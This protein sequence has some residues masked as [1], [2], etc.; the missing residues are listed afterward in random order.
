MANLY[1][2]YNPK[3]IERYERQ[4][5]QDCQQN[6]SQLQF[7][8]ISDEWNKLHDLA[9]KGFQEANKR[10][11]GKRWPIIGDSQK[12]DIS[13]DLPQ[14][15]CI[16][17]AFAD[18]Y[19]LLQDLGE[20][21]EPLIS[22]ETRVEFKDVISELRDYV[23]F[24]FEPGDEVDTFTMCMVEVKKYIG[25]DIKRAKKRAK[26]KHVRKKMSKRKIRVAFGDDIK[27][28]FTFNE[29][30]AFFDLKDLDLPSGEAVSIL[31]KLVDS[32]GEVVKHNKLDQNSNPSNASDILKGRIHT[33][34][35]ALKRQ[36]KIPCEIKPKRGAGYV[37]QLTRTAS[38]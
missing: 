30:Q 3:D 7:W 24:I 34:K 31:K 10:N 15:V 1:S 11:R 17:F 38:L 16:L 25:T 20:Y 19:Q 9:N 35:Q 18:Y 5:E 8:R 26:K 23:T 28:L 27:K 29:A 2:Y 33:I 22:P 32:F 12:T 21:E 37:L 6:Y 4:F 36:K 14:A 13:K